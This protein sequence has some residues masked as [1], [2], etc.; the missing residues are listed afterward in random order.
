MFSEADSLAVTVFGRGSHGSRP[1]SS[2]DPIVLASMIVIRLQTIVSREIAPNEPAVVTVGKIEAGIKSNVIGDSAQMQINVRSYSQRT[3]SRVLDAI[4]RIVMAECQASGSPRDPNFEMFGHFPLTSNDL[5][6][7][8]RVRT[9]FDTQ[10]GDR[11]Q[12]IDA[13]PESE[14]FGD[15]PEALGAPYVYW[16]IGAIDPERYKKAEDAGRVEQDI[17]VNHSPLFAPAI[18]P[19]LDTGTQ[20]LVAASL[21]WLGLANDSTAT[22]TKRRT[23]REG[24]VFGSA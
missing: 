8:Q 24:D 7:T 16:G 17:P 1:Q 2:V 9:A 14:D 10:F 23:D 4:R 12:D 18:Q 15:I 5:D 19:T 21:A 20:A 11:S 13:Q 22:A 3:Q 6:S